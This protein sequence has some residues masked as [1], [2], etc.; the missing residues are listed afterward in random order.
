MNA[1][2]DMIQTMRACF[3]G[4]SLSLLTAAGCVST[5]APTTQPMTDVDP[6]LAEPD[7]WYAQPALSTV[8]GT[9]FDQLWSAAEKTA[10]ALMFAIDRQ[11]R[12]GGV[13]T[14]V[15]TTSS[16]FFEPWRQE[17]RDSYETA[18]SSLATI[19]RTIR[20][21]FAKQEDG[22]YLVTPKVLIERLAQAENRVTNVVLYKTAFRP[23]RLAGD[24]A[25]FGTRETDKGI[26]LPKKYWYAI[27]RDSA[28][29]SAIADNMRKRL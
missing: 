5:S 13:L 16:Q 12:R 10:R 19:R 25:A 22:S 8:A 15:P 29:E 18:Q 14:T 3:L 21:E 9:D 28:L 2:I 23:P 17:Q 1:V 27:G 6:Q 24:M 20:F 4:V 26:Y 7:Y 11:D